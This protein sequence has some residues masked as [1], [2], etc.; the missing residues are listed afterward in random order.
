MLATKGLRVSTVHILLLSTNNLLR[1]VHWTNHTSVMR[2][3]NTFFVSITQAK[4]GERTPGW[5]SGSVT[6]H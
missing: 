3:I 4:S 1:P 2:D 6:G 5:N